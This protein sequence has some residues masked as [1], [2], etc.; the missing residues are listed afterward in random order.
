[1]SS[2][3]IDP[4]AITQIIGCVY[5]NPSLLDF[6]DKYIITENDFQEQLHKIIFGTIYKL[7]ELGAKVITLESISDFL[8][9]RPKSKGIYDSQN[10]AEWILKASSVA[11]PDAFDYYYSRLKKFSLLRAYDNYG[12][13]VSF[14][15]D[16]NNIFDA[17][18]KQ[19]QEDQ[20]DNSRLDELAQKVD[21]RI[22]AIRAE[23]VDQAYGESYQAGEGIDDLINSFK[24]HPE[25]GVPLFGPLI[26]TVTRGARLK[27]FYLR[28]APS[29]IG[30]AIPNDTLIPTPDGWRKVGDI[31]IG[32][33]LFGKDGLP[34]KVLN[35]YPQGEK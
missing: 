15:Y 13:D 26:N 25:V 29:G 16:P 12:V 32:D 24:E 11:I 5:N 22:N 17:K 14:I 8:D 6:T 20:L 23:Y 1:M 35:T 18:K 21:D 10:G 27:K 31:K 9:E 7:Y 33:Y 3:Y 4:T 2:K 19:L 30:K 28:S 34:T